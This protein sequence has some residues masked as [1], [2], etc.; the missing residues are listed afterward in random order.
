MMLQQTYKK[1]KSYFY[2][3]NLLFLTTIN[4]LKWV[5]KT[6]LIFDINKIS[7]VGI[8]DS[9]KL[10]LQKNLNY[11]LN[12]NIYYINENELND[13]INQFNFIENYS[14]KK[15]FPSEIKI[16]IK[17]TNLLANTF[18]KEK[19]Y[20]I[21]S[22]GKLIDNKYFIIDNELPNVFGN[23]LIDDFNFFIRIINNAGL[24]Y[25]E[26]TD[27]YYYKNGRWDIKLKNDIIIKLPQDN[28][29][30]SLINAKS[31]LENEQIKQN[32]I[33]DLRIP[34]QVILSNE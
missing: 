23:F 13:K 4:N 6:H 33:I 24:N 29:F 15:I 7:I 20:F 25:K 32:K 12:K 1:I 3:I 9:L 17:Q 26:F 19:K 16:A 11:L 22:N 34:N 21:G 27:Y 18:K 2:I 10:V 8:D 30:N 31:L 14:I 28:V 5:G